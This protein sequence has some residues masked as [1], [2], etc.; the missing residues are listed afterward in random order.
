VPVMPASTKDAFLTGASAALAHWMGEEMR[1]PQ[2]SVG[3]RLLHRRLEAGPTASAA[4]QSCILDR[5][6]SLVARAVARA[7][8]GCDLIGFGRAV[9]AVTA[10]EYGLIASLIAVAVLTV[11][12]TVGTNLSTTFSTIA[13]SL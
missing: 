9:I 5:D 10:I 12:G 11:M 8:G 6:I 7:L 3:A 1:G 13:S 4:D 2:I